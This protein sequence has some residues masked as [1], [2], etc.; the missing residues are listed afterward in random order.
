MDLKFSISDCNSVICFSCFRLIC[1]YFKNLL[2]ILNYLVVWTDH[3]Y[4]E[5]LIARYNRRA[6]PPETFVAPA[7]KISGKNAL[8]LPTLLTLTVVAFHEGL[9]VTSIEKEI[10]QHCQR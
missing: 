6:F 4:T 1:L 9:L 10:D 8:E 5:F 2:C 3:F 7:L